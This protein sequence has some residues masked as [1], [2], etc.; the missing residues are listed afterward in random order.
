MPSSRSRAPSSSRCSS[1]SAPRGSATCSSRRASA[2][3]CII[4]ID[5]LDALGRSR[6]AGAWSAAA[7]TRRSRRSTSCWPRWTASIRSTGVMLLA[8]TNR[9]EILDPALLRAGRFDRQVLVDR[10]DQQGP[11]ADPRGALRARCG[12]LR[13]SSSSR[14]RPDAGLDRRR[15]GQHGERGG[16][17]ATRRDAEAVGAGRTSTAAIERI[18]AGLE[19]RNRVLNPPERR[20]W[21]STRWAMRWSRSACRASIRCRRCRSS[22]AASARSATP[23]SGRPRTASCWRAASSR[24]G[25]PC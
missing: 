13:T 24:T 14:S 8:A 23:C 12:W 2:A 16:L 5:E 18:V 10:P 3:P 15:P 17:V 21:P 9:P 4:F 7:T 20:A 25:S 1:A 22:R 11:R 19:K 6:A